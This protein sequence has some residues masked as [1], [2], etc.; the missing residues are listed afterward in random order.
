[1]NG[2][3]HTRQQS[4]STFSFCKSEIDTCEIVWCLSNGSFTLHS[5]L[6]LFFHS[7]SLL[8]LSLFFFFVSRIEYETVLFLPHY[9]AT[10]P[11]LR[12]FCTWHMRTNWAQ[13][14]HL[15]AVMIV[16]CF[17]SVCHFVFCLCMISL[18]RFSYIIVTNP[19]HCLNQMI[20]T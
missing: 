3:I 12:A 13:S 7:H 6:P 15:Q 9:M 18:W 20:T 14:Y 10:E 5:Y 4:V 1:M 2:A 8:F 17:L 16:C 11:L 19:K